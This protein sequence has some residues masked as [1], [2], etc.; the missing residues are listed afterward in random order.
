M[1]RNEVREKEDLN[2]IDHPFADELFVMTNL[3][4]LSK[5]EEYVLRKPPVEKEP[6]QLEEEPKDRLKLITN[7]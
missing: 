5:F 6:E 2:P 4:P 1:T 3:V 7:K